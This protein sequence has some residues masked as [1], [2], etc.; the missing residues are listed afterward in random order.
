[1]VTL[2]LSCAGKMIILFLIELTRSEN[3]YDC[4]KTSLDGVTDGM[5]DC[6]DAPSGTNNGSFE[7]CYFEYFTGR[8]SS[9]NYV[10]AT[11]MQ[12]LP[13]VILKLGVGKSY[14]Q[15]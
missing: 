15:I 2:N 10:N 9:E 4:Y 14:C 5:D 6:S 12:G 11:F 8:V 13:S 3:C 7:Q 1:M